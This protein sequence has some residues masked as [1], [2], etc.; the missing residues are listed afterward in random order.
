MMIAPQPLTNPA[1]GVIPTRPV[2]MP[3]TA[4]II[5]GLSRKM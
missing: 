3:L 2:I 5:D 4:P 1:A